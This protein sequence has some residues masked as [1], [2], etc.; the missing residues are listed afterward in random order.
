MKINLLDV[1]IDNLS[2]SEV[3][4][5][6]RQFLGDG[7]QHK[8]FTPNPEMLVLAARNEEFRQILKS[9]DILVPDGFGLIL[10]SHLLGTPFRERIPGVDLAQEIIKIA[11]EENK[12]VFLLGGKKGTGES[13]VKN[14][15]N[16]T[17]KKLP[18]G[19]FLEV[20]KIYYL[21]EIIIDQHTTEQ[22]VKGINNKN[23]D[24]L[25]VAFGQGRQERFIHENLSKMPSVKI[26]IGVGGALDFISGHVHRAPQI[27]QKLGLEWLWRLVLQPWRL[28]RIFNAV[29]IF[30]V[31]VFLWQR[32]NNSE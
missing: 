3:L 19:N 16:Q 29:V 15:K 28:F 4:A 20:V 1:H 31:K 9:A 10:V 2:K 32:T 11:A 8:I 21:D 25:F 30:P 26:A 24:I 23:P 5:K 14:L 12:I 27:L 6:V 17:S 18:I 13:A 7:G 22:I